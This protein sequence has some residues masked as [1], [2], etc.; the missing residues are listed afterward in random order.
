LLL[1]GYFAEGAECITME[2]S[3]TDGLVAVPMN[4]I[5]IGI[6][7]EAGGHGCTLA[8]CVLNVFAAFT[9]IGIDATSHM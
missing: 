2:A 8:M 1:D 7:K 6:A 4:M 3:F 9:D 5:G